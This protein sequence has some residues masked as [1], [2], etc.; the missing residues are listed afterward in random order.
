MNSNDFLVTRLN[1]ITEVVVQK[2]WGRAYELIEEWESDDRLS[3]SPNY[4]LLNSIPHE[5]WEV[6]D[7]PGIQFED[8]RECFN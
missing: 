1:Q 2:N 7:N 3:T 4:S 6:A 5:G 8:L